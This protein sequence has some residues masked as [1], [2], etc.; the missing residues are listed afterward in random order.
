ILQEPGPTGLEY[1]LARLYAVR[2]KEGDLAKA[3]IHGKRA[4][5]PSNPAP[6]VLTSKLLGQANRSQEAIRLLHDGIEKIPVDKNVFS[7]YLACA[8][9]LSQSNRDEEAIQLLKDGIKRIPPDKH[10]VAIYQ[11]CAELLSRANRNEEAIDLLKDGIKRIPADKHV[12]A[13]YQACAELL[14]QADRNEEAIELLLDS[15]HIIPADKGL[16]E[17]YQA[18]AELLNQSGRNEEAIRLLKDGIPQ[19]PAD[20]GLVAIYQAC[21]DFLSQANRNKE[22]IELLKE[23]IKRVPTN[24]GGSSLIEMCAYYLL[25]ARN[26]PELRKLSQELRQSNIQESYLVEL[27]ISI[28]KREWEKASINADRYRNEFPYYLPITAQSAFINLY[29]GDAHRAVEILDDYPRETRHSKGSPVS[30]L[31][32]C[33]YYQ[34]KQYDLANSILSIF[35]DQDVNFNPKEI[36]HELFHS[37]KNGVSSKRIVNLYFPILI[38]ILSQ[39][40]ETGD[41]KKEVKESHQTTLSEGMSTLQATLAQKIKTSD[42]D[43]FL[44]HNSQN[45]EIIKCIGNQLKAFGILPWLDEWEIVPGRPWQDALAEQ[46]RNIK[47]VAV[48]IGPEGI[49]PWQNTE[50]NAFLRIFHQ[51]Q[52]PIIPVV[53]PSCDTAPE[54]PFFLEGFQ[55]VDFRKE[56]PNP[57]HQLLWGITE[58]KVEVF[59]SDFPDSPIDKINN[60][61]LV[62]EIRGVIRT[63]ML[64]LRNEVLTRSDEDTSR[65]INKLNEA[66]LSTTSIIIKSIEQSKI[67]EEDMRELLDG[68]RELKASPP[69]SSEITKALEKITPVIDDTK[70]GVDHKLKLTIPLIP[71]ILS[72]EGEYKLSSGLNFSELIHRITRKVYSK[73]K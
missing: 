35:K 42:F 22:V 54:L 71:A 32:A 50:L 13:I 49:G 58:T 51:K 4:L 53:L 47:S 29:M 10:V 20:K 62:E 14:S 65:I 67:D 48:F 24:K 36:Q 60:Q 69:A 45:K 33:S 3:I 37:W 68:V 16:V 6:W 55:W 23:G 38:P 56:V 19:I 12:V 27:L 64:I 5:N 39:F 2:D 17:I 52:I 72:Y 70:F 11:A 31:M 73:V 44:C 59:F 9:L 46:I 18:C 40:E 8:E 43:V 61:S 25:N 63:E 41:S 34:L 66:Q 57:Y 15:I 26:E 28:L 30:W 21:A 7:V 1:H